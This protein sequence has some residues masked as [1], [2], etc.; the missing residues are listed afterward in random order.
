[1]RFFFFIDDVLLWVR[2]KFI[3][4][5]MDVDVQSDIISKADADAGVSVGADVND[6]VDERADVELDVIP[7]GNMHFNG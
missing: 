6:D 4:L 1:L 7:A 2:R 5:G 3:L